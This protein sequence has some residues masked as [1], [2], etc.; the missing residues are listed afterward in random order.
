[1]S[2]VINSLAHTNVLNRCCMQ[3]TSDCGDLNLSG[4]EGRFT[5]LAHEGD[6]ALQINRL[7]ASNHHP[8]SADSNV[9]HVAAQ[10]S[11]AVASKGS[12]FARIAPTVSHLLLIRSFYMS[13]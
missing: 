3:V 10:E 12:I 6:I 11:S 1:M 2:R 7:H 13:S 9:N 4:I 8:A 5:A